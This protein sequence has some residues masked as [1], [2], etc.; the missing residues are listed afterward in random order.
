MVDV[1]AMMAE[2]AAKFDL[3]WHPESDRLEGES[4]AWLD[5]FDWPDLDAAGRQRLSRSRFGLGAGACFP[6]A[7]Y[8]AVYWWCRFS[9]FYTAVDDAYAEGV[10]ASDIAMFLRRA[11]ELWS[12]SEH[13]FPP[14]KP[15]SPPAVGLAELLTELDDLVRTGT[16]T[17]IVAARVRQAW[18]DYLFAA[19]WEAVMRSSSASPISADWLVFRRHFSFGPLNLEF[20]EHLPGCLLAERQRRFSSVRDLRSLACDLMD[21]INDV[22]S[23]N[24]EI[25]ADNRPLVDESVAVAD[26]DLRVELVFRRVRAWADRFLEVKGKLAADPD[27]ARYVDAVSGW[28]GGFIWF[29]RYASG[30]RYGR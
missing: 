6:S 5:R 27:M 24:Y 16:V 14:A 15:N 1:Q 9:Y 4:V 19:T 29:Y 28:V 8:A 7:S 30:D 26:P 12:V 13:S 21:E 25:A 18:R 17:D 3:S 11:G 23:L 2:L 10:A 20:L 22:Y